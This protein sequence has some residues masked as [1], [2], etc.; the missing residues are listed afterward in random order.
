MTD[1]RAGI[2]TQTL[3]LPQPNLDNRE[4]YEATRRGEL[5]FQR[6]S[7]CGAWRHYPRPA[8]PDCQSRN[9]RWELA[10][11]RGRVYSWTIVHGP[12]LPAFQEDLPYNVVDVLTDEGLHFQSQILDCPP[13]E[14]REGMRLEAVFVPIDEEI[15]LVKFRRAQGDIA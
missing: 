9:F 12:T 14:I 15:T 6:C 7:D 5:R 13:H 10:S 3:P 1:L 4:F 11:G 8:C 2:I